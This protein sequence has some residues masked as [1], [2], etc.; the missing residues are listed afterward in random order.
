MLFRIMDHYEIGNND[1]GY[2]PITEKKAL[3]DE[4]PECFICFEIKL[5]NEKTP[6]QLKKQPYFIKTCV[7]NG[8]VHKKCLN[9]WYTNSQNCPIC[10]VGM[11]KAPSYFAFITEKK[12]FVYIPTILFKSICRLF[13][14]FTIFAF[15]Y[16]TLDFYTHIFNS[17]INYD[18][19]CIIYENSCVLYELG[20]ANPEN[21]NSL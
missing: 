2:I 20:I 18:H 7:C 12:V 3:P 19:S 1:S 5:E 8:F 15:I 4:L 21:V 16:Y 6:I 9:H 10:R 17:K 13:R 14:F 11:K